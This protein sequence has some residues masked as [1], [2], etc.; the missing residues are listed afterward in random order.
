[1][2]ANRT[3]IKI[4]NWVLAGALSIFG[5]A[6][7]DKEVPNEYGTPNADFTVKGAVVD[8]ATGKAI[9]GISVSYRS[10][11]EPMYMYGTM[12]TSFEQKSSVLTDAK[13]EFKITKNEFHNTQV[14]LPV[15]VED[16][17]G[18]E[19]GLFQS[20]TLQVDFSKAEH[21][22]KSEHWYGGEYTVAVNVELSEIKEKE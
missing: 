22:G 11:N 7:S 6:C 1:M 13:G 4:I 18:E 21:S 20:E 5:Y 19:N 2:K 9:K 3:I 14:Q 17:D 15:F 12:Q 16:I 10:I 8:K